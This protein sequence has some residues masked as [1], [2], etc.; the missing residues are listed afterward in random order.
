MIPNLK[1]R[2]WFL[3]QGGLDRLTCL[4]CQHARNF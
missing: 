4:E 1:R 3:Q 2:V